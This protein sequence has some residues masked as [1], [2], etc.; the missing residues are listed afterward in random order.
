MNKRV[1]L[2]D[3]GTGM[4]VGLAAEGASISGGA[5]TVYVTSLDRGL[6]KAYEYLASLDEIDLR[7]WINVESKSDH[8]P[9]VREAIGGAVSRGLGS[10]DDD[11]TL[12]IWIDKKDAG[13]YWGS[14]PLDEEIWREAARITLAHLK[15]EGN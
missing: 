6:V 15:S 10:F 8:T 4:L 11:R 13:L 2:A 1:T 3:F 7:F 5:T 9:T 14:L 12:F